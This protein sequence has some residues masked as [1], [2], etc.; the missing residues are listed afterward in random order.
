MKEEVWEGSLFQKILSL[1]SLQILL[2]FFSLQTLFLFH[3]SIGVFLFFFQNKVLFIY[4]REWASEREHRGRGRSRTRTE[5]GAQ[6]WARSQD[7]GITTL[8]E[9]RC[10][11]NW[12]T[13]C[14]N[15]SLFINKLKF[16]ILSFAWKSFLSIFP[17]SLFLY[18]KVY[19]VLRYI[20]LWV[21]SSSAM[22]SLQF[23]FYMEFYFNGWI[24]VWYLF[25]FLVLILM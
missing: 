7:P 20:F 1:F 8:V 11:S 16:F 18:I 13:R 21:V 10:L 22:F 19:Y 2:L 3:L 25:N 14:P 5:Q 15:W 24:S 17:I 23:N 6:F 9:G 12:A 4:L